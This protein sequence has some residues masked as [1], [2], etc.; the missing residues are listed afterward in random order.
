MTPDA[1]GRK[2]Y[3]API[4]SEKSIHRYPMVE[5]D[6][7]GTLIWLDAPVKLPMKN[8]NM[9]ALIHYTP[10]IKH[11]YCVKHKNQITQACFCA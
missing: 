3:D 6:T 5:I 11:E 2:Y 7:S 8:K 10:E 4:T 1:P 9:K